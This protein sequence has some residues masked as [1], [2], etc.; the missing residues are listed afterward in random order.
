[1]D[2]FDYLDESLVDWGIEFSIGTLT[3]RDIELMALLEEE[4]LPRF[5]AA[6]W[7]RSAEVA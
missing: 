2:E 7:R 1:M 6:I 3:E 5:E 4:Y